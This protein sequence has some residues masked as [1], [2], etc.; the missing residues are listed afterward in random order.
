[1][2]QSRR[3]CITVNRHV[4]C[5]IAISEQLPC[6]VFGTVSIISGKTKFVLS[7]IFVLFTRTI[8]DFH[9]P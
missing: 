3:N 2:G 7:E 5:N 6:T 8:V 4:S 9:P 1:M